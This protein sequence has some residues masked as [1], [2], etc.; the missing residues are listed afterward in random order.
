MISARAS[1]IYMSSDGA[2]LILDPEAEDKARE[3][4]IKKL[5]HEYR[6]TQRSAALGKDK[7]L[8]RFIDEPLA[9]I[10][11]Y[12]YLTVFLNLLTKTTDTIR[13]GELYDAY[14]SGDDR[15]MADSFSCIAEAVGPKGLLLLGG[16]NSSDCSGED[17]GL[18]NLP[19]AEGNHDSNEWLQLA[20]TILALRDEKDENWQAKLE[21]NLQS[22]QI[23]LRQ[24]EISYLVL[25]IQFKPDSIR[26]SDARLVRDFFWYSRLKSKGEGLW[27]K[28]EYTRR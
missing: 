4:I 13:L 8:F 14:E 18:A 3:E 22:D 5:C 1:V 9:D 6:H 10:I 28:K 21:K 23:P 20:E 17:D 19:L 24:L 16:K 25:V 27:V 26:T 7:G 11:G 2:R 15:Q 12:Q